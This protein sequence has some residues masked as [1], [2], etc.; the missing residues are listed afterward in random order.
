MENK[1]K[2]LSKLLEKSELAKNKVVQI[3][4]GRI[5]PGYSSAYALRCVR[6][7][8]DHPLRRLLS[9]GGLIFRDETV[10]SV[11]QYRS[12]LMTARAFMNGGRMFE[13]FLSKGIW[14]RRKYLKVLRS[15]IQ[16]SRVV[17]FEGPW[18]Y[19]LVKDQLGDRIVVYDAHNVEYMLREGDRWE[20]Y[21]KHLESALVKRA[22]HI[23]TLSKENASQIQTIYGIGS[24]KVTA[25]PEGFETPDSF[26]RGKNS[27]EVVFI[28]SAY[29]PNIVAAQNV[30]SIAYSMPDYSFKIVGSV[31]KSIRKYKIPNNVKLL[32][33]LG[34]KDKDSEICSSF[35]AI[36][37]IETGSGRNTKIN[38]YVSH[39]TPIVTT[40][41]GARGFDDELRSL[42][43]I[44]DIKE[45]P[46]AIKELDTHR[47]LLQDHSNKLVKFAQQHSY[48]TTKRE[49]LILLKTLIGSKM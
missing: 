14:L 42:F 47:E 8:E 31:C 36:N 11:S 1:S 12:L 32:G 27:K 24:E 37:P 34:E 2:Q 7:L 4:H 26:W 48:S 13:I 15:E 40:E 3:A 35:A 22:D 20:G 17:I 9:V 16:T 19:N 23:V 33:V 30:I 46:E 6:Y 44:V 45:F 39:G 43:K 10:D 28:G 41:I 18:Q 49:M 21:T 38:D 5:I 29:R 25:V